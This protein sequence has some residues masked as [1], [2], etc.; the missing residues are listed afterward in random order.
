MVMDFV[1][2]EATDLQDIILQYFCGNLVLRLKRVKVYDY[3]FFKF[4]RTAFALWLLM[5]M[6]LL[7]VP[8]YGAYLMTA[9]GLMM[10]FVNLVSV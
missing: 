4:E 6:M 2:E 8:R 3:Y 7:V 10:L 9:T 1:G 5:N